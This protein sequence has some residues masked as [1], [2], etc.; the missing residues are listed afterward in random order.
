M[1][2]SPL[3]STTQILPYME[4]AMFS[5]QGHKQWKFR[6][7]T[8][9]KA[10]FSHKPHKPAHWKHL[11][12]LFSV[13]CTIRNVWRENQFELFPFQRTWAYCSKKHLFSETLADQD[14]SAIISELSWCLEQEARLSVNNIANLRQIF[15]CF[16]F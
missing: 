8:K 9:V 16:L 11:L 13:F 3:K 7:S 5:L 10:L 15:L 14:N 4:K 2:E 12:N 6:N 1:V